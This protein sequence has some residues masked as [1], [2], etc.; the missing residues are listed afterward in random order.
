MTADGLRLLNAI[1]G[2][3]ADVPLEQLQRLADVMRDS[4]RSS[5]TFRFEDGSMTLDA[6]SRENLTL[7]AQLLAVDAFRGQEVILAGFSDGSGQA[8]ANLGLKI[9]F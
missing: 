7:L 5:L 6:R 9:G 2:A 1:K 8:Q 3:G 4:S